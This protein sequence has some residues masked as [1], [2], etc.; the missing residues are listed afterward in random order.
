MVMNYE[1][2]WDMWMQNIQ[3]FGTEKILKCGASE[4]II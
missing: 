4:H 2:H 3:T 1:S